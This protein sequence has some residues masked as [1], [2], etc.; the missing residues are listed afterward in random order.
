MPARMSALPVDERGYPVPWFVHWSDGKPDFRIMD[1]VKRAVAV[2][3]RKCWLC[4]G[5]LGRFQAFVIGPMCAIN[6]VT[7]EPPSHKDCAIYAAMACPFLARPHAKRREAGLPENIAPDNGI[8][9]LH[10][11]GV[12]L[13]W[14]ARSFFCYSVPTPDNPRGWL[15][16]VGDPVETLW[17]AEGRPANRLEVLEA[18]SRGLPILTEAAKLQGREAE[19]ELAKAI[20]QVRRI[21]PPPLDGVPDPDL[22]TVGE[23]GTNALKS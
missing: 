8:A 16:K 7:Q 11:P 14:I 13:V 21:L 10:N 3:Q 1:N 9:L 6:R 22:V 2:T 15:I 23:G 18:I 19:L 12:C 17:Y 4:G 5:Q 20:D